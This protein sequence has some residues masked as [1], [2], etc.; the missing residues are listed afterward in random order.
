MLTFSYRYFTYDFEEVP[1]EE[2]EPMMYQPEK[3]VY[4][5]AHNGWVMGDDPLRNFAEPGELI[6]F[7]SY[8][9]MRGNRYWFIVVM[10]TKIQ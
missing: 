8:N 2:E 1:F 5:M 7:E 9:S 3:A 6:L 10:C 4:F